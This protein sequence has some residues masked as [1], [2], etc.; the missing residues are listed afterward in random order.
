MNSP[1]DRWRSPDAAGAV[2]FG[3][4]ARAEPLVGSS[5]ARRG[6]VGLVH[7]SG[8]HATV[9]GVLLGF[10]VPVLSQ[11]DQL[12]AETLEHRLRPV[13]AGF[14]VPVLRVLRGG[15]VGR[16]MVG[17]RS[18]AAAADHRRS[19]CRIGSWQTHRVLGTTFVLAKFTRAASTTTSRGAMSSVSRC[20]L[21]SGSQ[22]R[23]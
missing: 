20:W 3:R 1:R 21:G 13:S 8:V 17:D 7:A 23:Y 14:V 12:T 9:A 6:N 19:A 2:R 18:H 15:G 5:A 16:R 11:R 10:T 22:F 4:A